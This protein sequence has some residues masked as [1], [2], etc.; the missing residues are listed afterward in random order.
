MRDKA[1]P[2]DFMWGVSTAAYQ[3]EGAANEDGRGPSIWDTFSHTPGKVANGDTGDVACDHYHRYAEDID[4]IKGLGVGNYRFSIA[5]PRIIPNGVGQ[6]NAAGVD[7]YDR[8]VD[9]LLEKGVTPWPTLFHWDL[10]QALE[11]A[12]GWQNRD[13]LAWFSEYAAV[14][15]D[16]LGDRV[17]DWMIINEPS[18]IA[19]MGYGNGINAPGIVGEDSYL[20]A[21]HNL[22]RVVGGVYKLIKGAKPDWRVG[23]TYTAMTVYPGEGGT[24]DNVDAF[25]GAWNHN[26]IEPVIH[27]RY[28][29][30]YA[31]K[32]EPLVVQG[33]WETIRA[34]LD[35]I[36]V[37][38][39]APFKV[40]PSDDPAD[41][42]AT[43]PAELSPDVPVTDMNWPVDPPEFYKT[44]K[45]LDEK[46][47]GVPL[48]VTE[49]GCAYD[50][51]PGADGAIHDTRRI[52]YLDAYI[53]QAL[54]ALNDGVELK[55]YFLW[56]LL[57]N[58]EWAAGYGKRFGLVHVDYADGQKRTPKDSY[59]WY[60]DVV[61]ANALPEEDKK[62]AAG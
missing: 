19:F 4:L 29:A 22:N 41:P 24:Q 47:P 34:D 7:F 11:D 17:T 26:Y 48:I 23:S 44:L 14:V 27:G 1:F 31:K 56:S 21:T 30:W 57:D 9:G 38:H 58:F 46:Y 28:P 33:D 16:A 49:N 53:G 8:L 12:G 32:F 37:Q 61:K 5:W 59:F 42:F 52:D 36:G 45:M 43:K 60:R 35:F 15:T 25:A 55:G 51:G 2:E 13:I 54:R 20:A 50:D 6:V 62:A 3:I 39:Y 40:V 10:P 18:V